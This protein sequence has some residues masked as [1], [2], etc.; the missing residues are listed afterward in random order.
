M[1]SALSERRNM[2]L[3]PGVVA[4]DGDGN[5][6]RPLSLPAPRESHAHKKSSVRGELGELE[7]GELGV[8]WG[9]PDLRN[10]PLPSRQIS[11]AGQAVP[12]PPSPSPPKNAVLSG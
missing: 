4:W 7:L 5:G 2:E 12:I 8:N 3:L 9:Q 1:F 6:A 11:R 10:F